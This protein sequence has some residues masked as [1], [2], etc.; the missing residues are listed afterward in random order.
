[1]STEALTPRLTP[2]DEKVLALLPWNPPGVRA[3]WIHTRLKPRYYAD[4]GPSSL[5]VRLILRGFEYL[6]IARQ[7]NGWWT[8]TAG[9]GSA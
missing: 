9:K 1:M 6:G 8:L 2:L 5:D 4:K 7:A 3:S